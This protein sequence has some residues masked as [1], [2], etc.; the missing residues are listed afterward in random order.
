MYGGG[1]EAGRA[2]PLRDTPWVWTPWEVGVALGLV[3]ALRGRSVV[4]VTHVWVGVCALPAQ[5]T[6]LS[7]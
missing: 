3:E 1:R 7:F 4:A 6:W 2:E 5:G